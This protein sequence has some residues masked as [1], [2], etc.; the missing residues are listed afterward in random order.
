M[1]GPGPF[2][3]AAILGRLL[4]GVTLT[5]FTVF[6]G[7]EREVYADCCGTW[8]CVMRIRHMQKHACHKLTGQFD[9]AVH[10]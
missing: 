9:L 8:K 2:S 6:G 10:Q 5:I 3:M 4:S 1:A 7:D